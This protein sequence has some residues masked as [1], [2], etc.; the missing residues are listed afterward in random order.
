MV[1]RLHGDSYIRLDD[2]VEIVQGTSFK[3]QRYVTVFSQHQNE[4]LAIEVFFTTGY[5]VC[6][7]D[8]LPKARC[9][10]LQILR[11]ITKSTFPIAKECHFFTSYCFFS[12]CDSST[13]LIQPGI[14][15]THP[16]LASIGCD[17]P[18]FSLNFLCCQN[19]R[20]HNNHNYITF[21]LQFLRN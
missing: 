9:G 17:A 14:S 7:Y 16:S 21:Y 20:L 8:V 5:L 2:Q 19:G 6:I 1:S 11:N 10:T 4:V 15:V 3:S 18:Q 13:T 12:F